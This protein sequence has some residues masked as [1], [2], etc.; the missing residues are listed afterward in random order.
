M[1]T[2]SEVL[3]LIRISKTIESKSPAVGYT[4][5]DG[6]KRCDMELKATAEGDPRFSVF[7]RQNLKFNENYSIGLRHFTGDPRLGSIVLVRY[8]GPHGE[9]SRHPDGHY[10]AP[11]I[12]RITANEIASGSS[13]PQEKHREVTDRYSTFD[14]ALFVFFNDI[15]V[16]DYEKYFPSL[17]QMSLFDGHC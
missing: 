6:Q 16:V 2:D 12:H 8:N 9:Y 1:L 11:H 5:V 7:I 10:A 13:H 14:Q 17:G 15:N 4:E 3:R